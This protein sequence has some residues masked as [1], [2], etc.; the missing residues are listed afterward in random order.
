MVIRNEIDHSKKSRYKIMFIDNFRFMSSSLSNPV[1]D[2]FDGLHNIKCTDF[3]SYLDIISTKE[4]ELLIFN[5]L[6]CSKKDKKHF[7]KELIN[8]RIESPS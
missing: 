4:D 1:D 6:K 2:L 3:K 7:N 5:S 8:N